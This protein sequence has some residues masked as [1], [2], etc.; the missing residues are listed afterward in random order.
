[1]C[2]SSF[3]I[4]NNEVGVCL[5]LALVHIILLAF[6]VPLPGVVKNSGRCD[7]QKDGHRHTPASGSG[8]WLMA[9][10][11]VGTLGDVCV[12]IGAVCS[13]SYWVSSA[14]A[15]SGTQVAHLGHRH[16]DIECNGK[17]ECPI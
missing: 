2:L 17:S 3:L 9:V 5:G 4:Q 8:R 13:L 7:V 6:F 1:V 12:G 10:C 15:D 14:E 11:V 16:A